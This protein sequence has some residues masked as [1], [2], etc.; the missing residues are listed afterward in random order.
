MLRT[1]GRNNTIS[2]DNTLWT[3]F[4]SKQNYGF[5]N[6]EVRDNA[7]NKG[8]FVQCSTIPQC[9]IQVFTFNGKVISPRTKQNVAGAAAAYT[10][11]EQHVCGAWGLQISSTQCKID[12]AVTP[13]YNVVC[14]E[15]ATMPLSCT[16][17]ATSIMDLTLLQQQCNAIPA[18]YNI[19]VEPDPK[20]PDPRRVQMKNA[21]NWLTWSLFNPN[22]NTIS[23]EQYVDAVECSVFVWE[24]IQTGKNTTIPYMN[25]K[26]VPIAGIYWFTL[27]SITEVPF[28]WWFR[29]I[30]LP[31]IPR[32][33]VAPNTDSIST[34]D[35]PVW[36]GD[37][38]PVDHISREN[39][40]SLNGGVRRNS[41]YMAQNSLRENTAR[42]IREYQ[43]IP[44]KGSRVVC[45]ADHVLKTHSAPPSQMCKGVDWETCRSIMY[46][47]VSNAKYDLLD[48]YV[49]LSSV[50]VNQ[51]RTWAE[52]EEKVNMAQCMDSTTLDRLD[53]LQKK[54]WPAYNWIELIDIEIVSGTLL[55]NLKVKQNDFLMNENNIGYEYDQTTA[56]AVYGT[57]AAY[58][59]GDHLQEFK[60]ANLK[61][62]SE[63]NIPTSIAL[64]TIWAVM[65]YIEPAC[66]D[67]DTSAM[68]LAGDGSSGRVY[69]PLYDYT[70]SEDMDKIY[71]SSKSN[72]Y[73]YVGLSGNPACDFTY[74][75][76]YQDSKGKER[77][78][79]ITPA[80]GNVLRCALAN[81]DGDCLLPSSSYYI[82]PLDDKLKNNAIPAWYLLQAARIV[83]E[84]LFKEYVKSPSY[85]IPYTW[86]YG[87]YNIDY[88]TAAYGQ[89]MAT[90]QKVSQLAVLSY[91]P[92]GYRN[93]RWMIDTADLSEMNA[94]TATLKHESPNAKDTAHLRNLYD[95][96]N[97]IITANTMTKQKITSESLPF[98]DNVPVN[99]VTPRFNFDLSD[100][101]NTDKLIL[102]GYYKCGES[103]T[104]ID[105]SSC[106]VRTQSLIEQVAASVERN[107]RYNGTVIVPDS[108][109]LLLMGLDSAHF[110]NVGTLAWTKANRGI[111]NMLVRNQTDNLGN[112]C[113][114]A[115]IHNS[116]CT[117]VNKQLYL[118]NPYVGGNFNVFDGCDTEVLDTRSGET[119]ISFCQFKTA[120]MDGICQ[121]FDDPYY[122]GQNS[123]C[124]HN[125]IANKGNVPANMPTNICQLYTPRRSD[126]KCDW[127]QGLLGGYKGVPITDLYN[128]INSLCTEQPLCSTGMGLFV[129]GGNPLYSSGW[130]TLSENNKP[131]FMKVSPLDLGGH[132]IV[133]KIS[134]QKGIYVDRVP[135][136]HSY[137][138]KSEL[139]HTTAILKSQ[140]S[141][142]THGDYGWLRSVRTAW[143]Q[144]S[145]KATTIRTATR[146]GGWFC[147]LTLHSRW[148][149]LN[150]YQDTV[151]PSPSRSARLF[152][153][154]TGGL[155][156]HPTQ[157]ATIL[158]NSRFAKIYTSN[159]YC[160]CN[161]ASKCQVPRDH[162][163]CGLTDTISST[164]DQHWRT[165][166]EL[167]PPSARCKQQLDWPFEGGTLR[168][169][170]VSP[171]DTA[172]TQPCYITDRLPRFQ[173]RYMP[174]GN[175]TRANNTENTLG[176]S[177][178]CHMV[179]EKYIMCF[180]FSVFL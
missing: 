176:V 161:N 10:R 4:Q 40:A 36:N 92:D 151:V 89:V 141:N 63:A 73:H 82:N 31:G 48:C 38:L 117:N 164:F 145:V 148:N 134:A 129:R 56:D 113:R 33:G 54:F 80:T 55:R 156:S 138:R 88:T 21:L 42:L 57:F 41:L 116:V 20:I 180:V 9:V 119:E 12:T 13:L 34:V 96:Y 15:R 6:S 121:N 149:A 25:E 43:N 130:Q 17:P 79:Y 168:D 177:G 27:F 170:M 37:W 95:R 91:Y 135:L 120:Q 50:D 98:L 39:I 104:V 114:R 23:A 105:Y 102:S 171:A 97:R 103:D 58:T 7:F 3:M 11:G 127:P 118:M 169:G 68:G 159:G 179:S 59:F 71:T 101:H 49:D 133:L 107:F 85:M 173:I 72:Q 137:T 123:N 93:C 140:L 162:A 111:E 136:M 69:A 124:A 18:I 44:I 157:P 128:E 100:A 30:V 87:A 2:V 5:L 146:P 47:R 143:E 155:S 22:V 28:A 152:A 165:V 29:C 163:D 167:D 76:P 84:K 106:D 65:C 81:A 126:A 139:A 67:P 115:S 112:V 125:N 52:F 24:R 74:S 64:G 16:S 70:K 150:R 166:V 178:A 158:Q 110:M 66:Y 78:T 83:I 60:L 174:V 32:K 45:E 14:T 109:T 132:H 8:D 46:A 122:R 99:W 175:V 19:F 1:F 35:C 147:P 131:G 62:W 86:A 90:Y 26:N 142:K 94:A 144:E 77:Y 61:F 75:A 172:N 154:L 53:R 160:L 153:N 51:V 108:H